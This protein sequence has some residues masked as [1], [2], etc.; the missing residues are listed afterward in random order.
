MTSKLPRRIFLFVLVCPILVILS[1]VSSLSLRVK[2]DIPTPTASPTYWMYLPAI[3]RD[4][5]IPSWNF[6]F[7]DAPRFLGDMSSR[8]IAVTSNNTPCIVYGNDHLYF[9]CLINER[10]ITSTVDSAYGVGRFATL[11]FDA[12]NSAH[13][14]YYDELNGALKYAHQVAGN[15][16]IQTVDSYPVEGGKALAPQN[17][18]RLDWLRNGMIRLGI[19]TAKT[20]TGGDPSIAVSPGGIPHISYYDYNLKAL[21]YAVWD[22][23]SWSR[24]T[25]DQ[26]GDVGQYSSIALDSAG[27]PRISYY[28]STNEDLKFAQW[29]SATWQISTVDSSGKVGKYTSLIL[30]STNQPCISYYRED[31]G[32]LKYAFWNGSAFQIFTPDADGNVGAYSSLARKGTDRVVIA[33]FDAENGDLLYR[34]GKIDGS[35]WDRSY[36]ID[37]K[38]YVGRNLSL[39]IDH[40]NRYHISYYHSSNNELRYAGEPT[41]SIDVLDRSTLTGIYPSLK[42]DSSGIIHIAYNNDSQDELRYLYW[43][44]SSWNMQIVDG[45]PNRDAGVFPSIAVSAWGA[46]SISYWQYDNQLE[47][48]YKDG[49]SW[50]ILV[51]DNSPGIGKDAMRSALTLDSNGFPR[52]AYYHPVAQS[53]RFA[54]WQGSSFQITTIDQS[55]NVGD[56]PSMVTDGEGNYWIAYYDIT[57]KRL[58]IAQGQIGNWSVTTVDSSS[59]SGAFTAIGL[60]SARRPH[61]IYLSGVGSQVLKHGWWNG[62]S[63]QIEVI[64]DSGKAGGSISLAT[65]RDNLYV[66]YSN[67]T[68]SDLQLAVNLGGG[69]QLF[70]VDAPGDVGSGSAIGVIN[71]KIVIAYSDLTNGDLKYAELK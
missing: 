7:L 40:N 3:F 71:G 57:N 21:R 59:G 56:Y 23:S 45:F 62:S 1:L 9:T 66:S 29:N 61:I 12:T 22:G 48:A 33:Y 18:G 35:Q 69:W 54:Y 30:S 5:F 38:D 43:N 65:M 31:I 60:D 70:T 25:V 55:G 67:S 27:K 46:P 44:G 26:T 10:W 24:M 8:S 11:A 52:I 36:I 50:E 49:N 6:S 16:V 28:D 64:D 63:W 17:P 51:V 14:A 15:W 47:Y 20:G 4:Y 2:A 34:E 37:E 53:L 42:V 39:A 32:D 13:V 19:T 68:S 58:K 41:E